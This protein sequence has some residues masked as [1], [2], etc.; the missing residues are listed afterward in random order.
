[1]A[2]KISIGIGVK[3]ND[4]ATTQKSLQNNL[5][6]ISK[7]LSL[8]IEKIK[9]EDLSKSIEQIKQ[10]MKQLSDNLKISPTIDTN[11]TNK[12][13]NEYV[14][15]VK[16]KI[17]EIEGETTRISN[18]KIST[19]NNGSILG[20]NATLDIDNADKKV[21]KFNQ[22]LQLLTKTFTDNES[23][24][25]KASQQEQ[26][27][28]TKLN[29]TDFLNRQKNAY[30]NLNQLL[31]EEYSVKRKLVTAEGEYKS[32]LEESLITNRLLQNEQNKNVK[33]N[34]LKNQELENNLLK[35]QESLL[36]EVNLLKS[37]NNTSMDSKLVSDLQ[38][39]ND[40][41][42][43]AISKLNQY[44]QAISQYN[45]GDTN[46][47]NQVISG[48]NTEINKLNE[49]KNA[50][51]LLGNSEKARISETVTAM[52]SET[53]ALTEHQHGFASMLSMMTQYAGVGAIVYG[54]INQLKQ[55]ITDIV[56]LD[57]AMRDLKRVSDDVSDSILNGFTK[58]ANQMAISLGQTT[59][60]YI[61][62]V[63]TFKQLGYEWNDAKDF[64]AKESTIL[65][66]VGDM[67]AKDS[68][69]AIVA[70]LKGFRLE[71]QDTTKVVDSLNEAGNKFAIRTGELA[72]G[73]RVS[74]AALALANND[75]YQSEA[76]ITAGT[77]VLRN[78]DEV[79][80]GLKTISMRLD[81]VKTKGGDTFFKLQSD[82]K[83]LADTELTDT[84]G[85]LRSTYDIILDISKAWDSGK[86][87]DMDKSK[88]LDET[89]GKQ[90]AKVM[91]SIIQNA[92]QLPKIYET[93]KNS[94]GSASEEQSRYMD[95][96]EGRLNAFKET[97]KSVWVDAIDSN[98]VK[99]LLSGA[100][101]IISVLD[102]IVEK[103][104]VMPSIIGGTTIALSMFN[105]Q[106][107]QNMSSYQPSFYANWIRGLNNI[108]TKLSETIIAQKSEIDA[109]KLMI[110]AH[111]EAGVS[112]VGLQSQLALMQTGL[113]ATTVKEVAC[114]I[115]TEALQL[116]FSMG[117]SLAITAMIGGLTE[118]GSYLFTTGNAMADCKEQSDALAKSLKIEND[119][120]NLIDQYESLNQKLSEGNK[121]EQEKKDINDQISKVK[122]DLIGLDDSYSWI[123]KDQNKTYEEQIGLLKDIYE[124]KALANAKDLDKSMD[125]QGTA[126]G[127]GDKLKNDISIYKDIQNALNNPNSDG[128]V[129]YR[130]FTVSAEAAQE[131]IGKVQNELKGYY[132]D[133]ETYNHNVQQLK[134]AN[135][136]T[137][138]SFVDMGDDV[139]AFMNNLNGVSTENKDV[140]INIDSGNIKIIDSSFKKLNDTQKVSESTVT[141]L[142]KA[143]P[144]LGINADNAKEKIA[145]LHAEESKTPQTDTEE[146]ADA[147][148]DKAKAIQDATNNYSKAT[149]AM[150]QAQIYADKLN[151]TQAL[152]PTLAK[153]M[154]KTYGDDVVGS[155]NSVA[156]A[157]EYLNNKI[158]EQKTI[159]SENYE[160]MMGDDTEFYQ[161][162]IAN[163]QDFQNAYTDLLNAFQTDGEQAYT[164]D[165]NNYKTL[166]E[167]KQ[168]TQSDLGVAIESW[169]E[170]L[171]GESAKNYGIDFS[172]FK[173]F[174]EAKAAILQKLSDD[175]KNVTA[176]LAT[177]QAEAFGM[178][179]T[180]QRLKYTTTDGNPELLDNL[181][182]KTEQDISNY[183]SKLDNLNNA[184]VKIQTSFDEFSGKI[185]QASVGG[186]GGT[187]D[188]GGTGGGSGSK[189]KSAKD[190]SEADA[191]KAQEEAVKA[192]K[193]SLK[194]ITDAY[195]K[196]KTLITDNLDEI[197]SAEEELG[198][199][200][201][202]EDKVNSINK[203]IAQQSNLLNDAKE[204]MIGLEN[205]SVSTEDGQEALADAFDKANE[206]I[207]G[208]ESAIRKLKS[209]LEDLVKSDLKD[210]IGQEQKLAEAQLENK[211]KAE[212]KQLEN[213]S[214]KFSKD[215]WSDYRK[216]RIEDIDN[217]IDKLHELEDSGMDEVTV[218]EAV[219]EKKEELKE[220]EDESYN[221]VKNTQE[222]YT[223]MM[224]QRKSNLQEEKDSIE[225]QITALQ[226]EH[227]A[228]QDANDLAE[229]KKAITEAQNDLTEKEIALNKLKSQK[230]IQSY[231]QQEDGSWNFT[232]TYDTSAVK[233]AQKDVDDAQSS[234]DSANKD[235]QNY[236]DEQAYNKEVD[237][238]KEQEDL[239][240]KQM[241]SIDELT[242]KKNDKYQEDL[243]NLQDNQ[244]KEKTAL[245]N[246][247]SD[248]DK[249]VDS[250]FAELQ[251]KYGDN[252][253]A[254]V[255]EIT[256]KTQSVQNQLDQ[257]TKIN[258]TYTVDTSGVTSSSDSDSSSEGSSS[259][260]N[261]AI[262]KVVETQFK[263][264][265][266]YGTKITGQKKS[267]DSDMLNEQKSFQEE[268]ITSSKDFLTEQNNLYNTMFEV[269]QNI[270]DWRWSNLVEIANM[271][272]EQ[273]LDLLKIEGDAYNKYVDMY[274]AMNPD[275][276]L[277]KVDLSSFFDAY[278]NYQFTSLKDYVND[279]ADLYDMSKSKLYVGS[280]S[281]DMSSYLNSN[282]YSKDTNLGSNTTNNSSSTNTYN[283]YGDISLPNI[284]NGDDAS[285]F[286]DGI[287]KIA[288]QKNNIK[289]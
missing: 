122:Q 125:S 203:Q 185:N 200:A 140:K 269:L 41:L 240:Q 225:D 167:L 204:E 118:L 280:K 123:L 80:T 182:A 210:L 259:T 260:E 129:S 75:L 133:L 139:K 107:K 166:N 191:K 256:T 275:D 248:M 117:L 120:K 289:S 229:K 216:S 201:T 239:L 217:E 141:S 150:A 94:A 255:N 91:A 14:N 28:N 50:N 176:Q 72:S 186:L 43:K 121:S 206:N 171:V 31:N 242:S 209:Q 169:L 130:G 18:I 247:Y 227:D 23:A 66:N 236:K 64:M 234:V 29:N 38:K 73:L 15:L 161:N 36:N 12:S 147:E 104:G 67:S 153:Q 174:A 286:F 137:G 42:D 46:N 198:D 6:K 183:K 7:N 110:D 87:S 148:Q 249:L 13:L 165:F 213:D 197:T 119:T 202:L 77:E 158:A 163:N 1:M 156:D 60:G 3:L 254:I 79:G 90:Q 278:N 25:I 226:E 103:F 264:V 243:K 175:I 222:A 283:I 215:E 54:A 267:D 58:Q 111:R 170:S 10:Q 262:T 53:N 173:S 47:Q 211:Q 179:L 241:D 195:D 106:F 114:T 63:T 235:L 134:D 192:D 266:E 74:S 127:L 100:T 89:A 40:Y 180:E 164:L 138:R 56:A 124:Q 88:L 17:A 27:N 159:Q 61:Q 230:T 188:F 190:T 11:T 282:G 208:Q 116:A 218:T 93:L 272:T 59:E 154:S 48:I 263:D 178:Q 135:Y 244:D 21:L 238:L 146:E 220:I 281:L 128:T 126:S 84:N 4:I 157:Q 108:K 194:E 8:N 184:K 142:A 35:Q 45:M 92:S 152:T 257:I 149:Q 279:K 95:S 102:K 68:A 155:L 258:L 246:S 62:A 285:S 252:W 187:T 136:T 145:Q 273:I 231:Q 237:A 228:Q 168:G 105:K 97:V 143:F 151:K 32:K 162:K 49:L 76:L 212:T 223:S 51:T 214:Y 288:N 199:N 219:K 30:A 69:N 160:I 245:E 96:I 268:S 253:D 9:F 172:N 99:G 196:A 44:K 34:N 82:L 287:V 39:Q 205:T 78:A 277:S 132:V 37:K 233:D 193:A 52:K 270:W 55:G 265:K 101:S 2:N 24:R 232:Y 224:E 16:S 81:Q 98:S 65:S 71:A 189:G 115:A 5:D 261:T 57:T 181:Q 109:T 276:T 33:D 85:N 250:R 131:T 274:N 83:N 177:S 144:K 20:A 113:V 207:K 112:T 22:D 70:T 251:Q 26:N 86:L 271:S 19:D 221:T 284:K